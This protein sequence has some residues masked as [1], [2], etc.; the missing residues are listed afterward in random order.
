MRNE[1]AD[2]VGLVRTLLRHSA[3]GRVRWPA[4]ELEEALSRIAAGM[5]SD[6]AVAR[7]W[8]VEQPCGDGFPGL[9]RVL[10]DLLASGVLVHVPTL[11][12][13]LVDPWRL[14]DDTREA[15]PVGDSVKSAATWLAQ[16]DQAAR[17]ASNT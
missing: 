6:A 4:W 8:R 12:C 3:V 11:G 17:A 7:R 1:H 14:G 15:G 2:R 5:G 16:R 10:A 13:Y 9:G